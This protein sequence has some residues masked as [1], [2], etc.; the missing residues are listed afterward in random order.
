[1]NEIVAGFPVL[2]GI[3]AAF[4]HVLS[5]P[6]HLA[7]VGPLALTKKI[8]PWLIGMAWGLGHLIGMLLIGMLFFFFKELIPVDFISDNSERIVGLL[9]VVIGVWAIYRMIQYNKTTK[10]AHVHTHEDESGNVFVHTH[11]HDH[12]SVNVHKHTHEKVLKQT[13]LAALGIG[14]LH[15]LAG[16]SHIVHLLPTL[17]FET[18]MESVEYL[19]GFGIGTVLAMMVFSIIIGLM[20]QMATQKKKDNIF[21]AING[22]AGLAAIVVG[23]Y[24]LYSTW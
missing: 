5:G 8:R 23:F 16:V 24:W 15:G 10:H 20:G 12:D 21:I 18:R 17:A 9:L 14:I 2:F 1:M 3:I 7:A 22:L 11:D 6:D 13:Y 19:V 4:A